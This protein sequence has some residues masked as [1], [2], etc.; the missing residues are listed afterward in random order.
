[1]VKFEFS[2]LKNPFKPISIIIVVPK[3]MHLKIRKITSGHIRN[4]PFWAIS[5]H[6][7][8]LKWPILKSAYSKTPTIAI[9]MAFRL[10][11]NDIPPRCERPFWKSAILK[12]FRSSESLPPLKF[13]FPIPKNPYTQN[14]ALPCRNWS[15]PYHLRNK[16]FHYQQQHNHGAT[17]CSSCHEQVR[18]TSGRL[19]CL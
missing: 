19:P 1:M 12:S 3:L 18:T 4:R 15:F 6:V 13:E 16:G 8:D 5:G 9:F 7:T 11:F 2:I 14:M 17:H 10:C